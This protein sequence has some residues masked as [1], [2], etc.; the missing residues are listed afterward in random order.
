MEIEISEPEVLHDLCDYLRRHGF[1]AVASSR[2]RAEVLIP[3]AGSDLAALLLL[4]ARIRAWR[5]M[6]PGIKVRVDEYA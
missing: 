2:E 4:R 5:G 1:V 6:N 3:D